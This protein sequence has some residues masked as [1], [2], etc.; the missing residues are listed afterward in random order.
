MLRRPQAQQA[1]RLP[2]ALA[3]AVRRMFIQT[4]GTPNPD[5]LKF[6]PGKSVLEGTTRDFRSFREAQASPLAKRLFQTEGVSSVFLASD[7]ITVSKAE[8]ADWMT[9]KPQLFASIM[10]FYATGEAAVL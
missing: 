5:S 4:E 8:D 9:L 3:G 2:S 7:F 10:D 6:L 1:R